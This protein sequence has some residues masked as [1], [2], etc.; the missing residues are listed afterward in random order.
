MEQ[1]VAEFLNKP[2][3]ILINLK[4]VL[5]ELYKFFAISFVGGGHGVSIHSVMEPYIAGSRIFCGPK[6]FRSTEF[7]FIQGKRRIKFLLLRISLNFFLSSV[8]N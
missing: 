3:V 8:S 2:G 5:C 6:V 7:Q 4:G 1:L